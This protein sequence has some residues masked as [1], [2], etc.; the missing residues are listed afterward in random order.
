[1]NVNMDDELNSLKFADTSN[2]WFVISVV[3][4]ILVILLLIGN[5]F[6]SLYT[7]KNFENKTLVLER[8][9]EKLLFHIKN[10]RMTTLLAASTGDLNWENEYIEHRKNTKMIL[11]R[12]YELIDTKEIEKEVNVI[13]RNKNNIN[14]IENKAYDLISQGKKEKATDVM[15]SWDYI[16]NQRELIKATENLRNIVHTHVQARIS[17]GKNIMYITFVTIFLLFGLLVF[18][19]Y[20]SIK[21]WRNN[22]KKRKEKED[23]IIYLNYHDS[24][25]DLYNRRY[26]MQ[27]AKEEIERAQR[28]DISLSFMMIDIDH[29]KKV[30]DDYGH[31]AGD[32]V[33]KN[34]AT[35]IKNGI[36]EIDIAGRLGGEE[37]GVLLP[38]TDLNKAEKLAERLRKIIEKRCF[39]Y[40]KLTISITVS[41]GITT[42]S[43]KDFNMDDLLKRADIA[44]Y[45]AK[46]R[47]RNCIV[48]NTD[49]KNFDSD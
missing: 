20:V 27:S 39:Q 31:A 30:N 18:S 4:T 25:T 7:I 29:F 34:L 26:L 47:G 45:E 44:L 38:E 42:Y 13:N 1:M 12:I 49:E 41:I 2:S 19:W 3:V 33:L 43:N 8:V 6:Y 24:L 46:S 5:L 23:E 40:Q 15:K 36:R 37:F 17:F 28:Y 21:S 9:S 16:H 11:K 32:E 22:I 35:E 10:L 48:K 14:E